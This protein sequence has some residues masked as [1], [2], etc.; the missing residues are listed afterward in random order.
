[1]SAGFAGLTATAAHAATG[2]GSVEVCKT[3]VSGSLAV[4]GSFTFTVAGYA[5]STAATPDFTTTVSVP[6]GTCSQPIPLLADD[7]YSTVTE[8]GAPSNTVTAI[9]V[10]A[11]ANYLVSSSLSTGSA[12]MSVAA[13]QTDTVTFTDQINAGYVEV[14]KYAATGSNLTGSFSFNVSGANGWMNGGPASAA[15]PAISVAVGSCSSPLLMPAGTVSVTEAGTNLYVTSI[16]ANVSGQ[17][18]SAI[19][20]TPNLIKGQVTVNV[21]AAAS[22]SATETIVNYTDNVVAFKVCKT[23]DPTLGAEPGGSATMFPFTLSTTS[24]GVTLPTTSLSLSAGTCSLVGTF[25]AGTVITTTEGI[26]PGSKVESITDTA[27]DGAESI[28][29]TPS[30]GTVVNAVTAANLAARQVTYVLGTPVTSTQAA[31]GNEATANFT[32]EVASPG[33]L[34]I[35]KYSGSTTLPPI[36]N[37]FTFSVSG[38]AY[39]GVTTTNGI[40]EGVGPIVTASGTVTVPVGGCVLIGGTSNG[41]Y[42]PFLFDGNVNVAE[43]ASTGNA[44]S[45]ITTAAQLVSENV[46]GTTGA[47]LLTGQNVLAASSISAGTSTVTIGEGTVTELNYFNIDPPVGGDP[48]VTPVAGSGGVTVTTPVSSSASTSVSPAAAISASSTTTANASSIVPSTSTQLINTHVMSVAQ[49][50]SALKADQ[51]ALKSVNA[52][53]AKWQKLAAKAHGAARKNDLKRVATL[54]AQA[55]NLNSVIAQINKA[56]K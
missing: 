14:C 16:Q 2:A 9:T 24:T 51:K 52:S 33:E 4:T 20:G 23:W 39:S 55:K 50:K 38:L 36:G 1:M 45:A 21:M 29:S 49:L 13:L 19:V 28:M 26:V 34:K 17:T 3:S 10:P 7:T 46:P 32:D 11:G 27:N 42:T 53:I 8:T 25:R 12:R 37:S 47:T 56:L 18:T 15:L 40:I 31:P 44:V 54:R 48:V 22:P 6:V 30:G 35:C 5:T 41:G 43:A